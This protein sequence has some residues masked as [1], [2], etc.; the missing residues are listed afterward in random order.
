MTYLVYLI[1]E[2]GYIQHLGESRVSCIN[3][4]YLQW[5][6]YPRESLLIEP[7]KAL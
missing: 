5:K 3:H 7:L 1:H 4:A 6:E 2:S